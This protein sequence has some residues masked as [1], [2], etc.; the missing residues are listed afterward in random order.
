MKARANLVC[1]AHQVN[2]RWPSGSPRSGFVQ[3]GMCIICLLLS[4]NI[5]FVRSFLNDVLQLG[6][7]SC[8]ASELLLELCFRCETKR[9]NEWEERDQMLR[10]GLNTRK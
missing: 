4:R 1:S 10:E 7:N 8:A 2:Y 9:D 3:V 5:F 6:R